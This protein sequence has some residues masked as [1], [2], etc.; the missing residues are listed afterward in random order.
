MAA[1]LY[2]VF[3]HPL[4]SVGTFTTYLSWKASA[5]FGYLF[6]SLTSAVLESGTLFR[7]YTLMGGLARSPLLVGAGGLV[8]SLT[9]AVALWV[10][11]RHLLATPSVDDRHARARV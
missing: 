4:L 10:L 6:N 2:L 9:S 8:F 11:Y 1:L 5:L 3:S 7:A